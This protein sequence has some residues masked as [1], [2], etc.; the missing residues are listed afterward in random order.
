MSG[1]MIRGNLNP[2]KVLAA[3]SLAVMPGDMVWLSSTVAKPASSEAWTSED[4][5]QVSIHT[6]FL[7][8]SLDQ[9]RSDDTSTDKY[10]TIATTG[11]YEVDHLDAETSAAEIGTLYGVA[12]SATGN[13]MENQVVSLAGT[14]GAAGTAHHAIG[15]LVEA[16]KANYVGAVKIE[17]Q[18]SLASGGCYE[19]VTS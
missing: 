5:D 4:A 17:L 12:K 13:A 3:P 8:V 1:R 14:T 18:S 15:R 19:I 7:G 10:I 11:V 9:R 6:L 16:I 2:I